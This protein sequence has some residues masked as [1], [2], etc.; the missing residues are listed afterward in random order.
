MRRISAPR[1]R[2]TLL[3]GRSR[4]RRVHDDRAS[5]PR[6]QGYGFRVPAYDSSV[7]PSS[8]DPLQAGR[9]AMARYAWDEAYEELA[10]AD[11]KRALRAEGLQLLAEAAWFASRP[12]TVMEAFE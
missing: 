9:E 8:E 2:S 6:H 7:N 3:I 1:E 5:G 11:R 10:E 12:D 4:T